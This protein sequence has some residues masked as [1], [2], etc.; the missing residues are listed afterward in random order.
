MSNETNDS[1]DQGQTEEKLY[2]GE[3][4]TME[5]AD[6]ALKKLKGESSK[7]REDLENEK[8]INNILNSTPKEKAPASKEEYGI[9]YSTN[10]AN[11]FSDEEAAAIDGTL[12]GYVSGLRK[13]VGTY[14][15]N[16]IVTSRQQQQAEETFYSQYKDLANFKDVVNMVSA[17]VKNE[18]GDRALAGDRTE[19]FKLVAKRARDYLGDT[20]KKLS[21]IDIHIEPSRSSSHDPKPPVTREEPQ[22]TT[23]EERSK[24]A[25]D[26]WKNDKNKMN[27]KL[28]GG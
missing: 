25:Y 7:L 20:K 12:K 10:L 5:E 23:A 22:V 28:I 19:L 13:E 3:Y 14:I 24:N 9:P 1:G 18:L 17:D 11:V 21:E 15:E 2:F 4:K 27:K 16:A 8:R 26:E 6:E